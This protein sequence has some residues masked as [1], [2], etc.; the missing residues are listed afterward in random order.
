MNSLIFN[1]TASQLKANANVYGYNSNTA[2][3]EILQLDAS[4]NL[5]ISA[6]SMT[7]T[8]TVTVGNSVTIANTSLTVEGTVTVGNSVTI[9]NTSLTVAGTVTVGNSVTIA[10]TSL[11]VLIN[12]NSFTSN[13]ATFEGVTGTA[14]I[15]DGTDVSSLRTATMFIN[16]IGTNP[17]TVN[18]QLS[19]DGTLYINDPN[20]TN[21]LI[22]GG[23][24]DI[25]VI[26]TF[27]KFVRLT[28]DAGAVTATFNAYYNGQA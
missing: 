9:A 12:G 27:S 3:L 4:G 16:N 22:S 7:V 18:L 14:N 15:F 26:S 1:T 19:P 13:T 8:G 2:T 10:N 11:T 20:Y 21:K 23:A 24:S 28:Y 25:A 17:I 5:L 6:T